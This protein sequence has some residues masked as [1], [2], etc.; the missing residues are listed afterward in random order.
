[1]I[2]GHLRKILNQNDSVEILRSSNRLFVQEL[3]IVQQISWFLELDGD[4]NHCKYMG[5]WLNISALNCC[6]KSNKEQRFGN[7][8]KASKISS[9]RLKLIYWCLKCNKGQRLGN[10]P[11]VSRISSFRLPPGQ[12]DPEML[13]WPRLRRISSRLF[14]IQSSKHNCVGLFVAEDS[15]ALNADAAVW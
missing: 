2:F 15:L 6:F 7:D 1:M 10:D 11:K 13:V 14:V 5:N 4:L 9:Y 12:R 3:W 8:P